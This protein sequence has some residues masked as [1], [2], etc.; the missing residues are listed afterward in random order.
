MSGALQKQQNRS[1]L[2]AWVSNEEKQKR[3]E[4]ML[5]GTMSVDTFIG[6]MM[7]AFQDPK[8]EKCSDQSKWDAIHQCAVLAIVPTLN[9][10]VL[11]PYGNEL[12][13]LPTWQGYKAVIERIPEIREI[14]ATLVHKTDHFV[15]DND[16]R[17][18]HR[19]NPLDGQRVFNSVDDLIGGYCRIVYTDGREDKYHFTTAQYIAKAQACAKSQNVWGKWFEQMA[20]KTCFRNCYA[21]RAV[22]V[23][24]LIERLTKQD[25]SVLENDPNRVQLSYARPKQIT[26]EEVLGL[27][28][29]QQI[30]EEPEDVIDATYTDQ[31]DDLNDVDEYGIEP[32]T[33]LTDDIVF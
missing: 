8:V 24:P 31:E 1:Q 27:P 9:Q 23:D 20:M 22:P 4:S 16:K 11:I 19:F 7:T 12:K 18:D 21:R 10:V 5:R 6:N 32:P 33:E 30:I 13:A 28:Q 17:P 25:D 14:T 15:P 2:V 26:R 3:F 29:V